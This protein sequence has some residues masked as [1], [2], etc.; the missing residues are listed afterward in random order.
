MDKTLRGLAESGPGEVKT[1][2]Q[3][4]LDRIEGEEQNESETEEQIE[5]FKNYCLNYTVDR[6]PV[7]WD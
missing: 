1:T 4:V 5:K 3:F 7:P 6:R 2:A